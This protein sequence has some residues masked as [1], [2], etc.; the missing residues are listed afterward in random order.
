[1]SDYEKQWDEE[2]AVR[3]LLEAGALVDGY[4]AEGARMPAQ[5]RETYHACIVEAHNARDMTAYQEAVN[6]YE[7]AAREAY[8]SEAYRR[9]GEYDR[10]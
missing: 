7:E 6:G 3:L 8:R 5:L 1:V 10:S 9:G 2:T 4:E